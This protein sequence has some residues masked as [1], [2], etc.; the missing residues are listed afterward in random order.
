MAKEEMATGP[1]GELENRED[2]LRDL[3]ARSSVGIEAKPA[4]PGSITPAA[5][6][7]PAGQSDHELP[8]PAGDR[9]LPDDP[10][11]STALP[12]IADPEATAAA[13]DEIILEDRKFLAERR[14]AALLGYSQ[15]QLQRWRKEHKGPPGTKIGRRWYYEMNKFREW[16]KR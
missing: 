10:A 9:R 13:S 2:A 7:R 5:E 8:V 16:T 1:S 14:V 12:T 11:T 4:E 6:P 15:R 3:P